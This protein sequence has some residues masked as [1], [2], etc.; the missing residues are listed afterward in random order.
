MGCYIAPR[1]ALTIE[2]V[3]AAIRAQP[4]GADLLVAGNINSNLEDLEGAPR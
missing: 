3:I 1:N 2:D 4:Y